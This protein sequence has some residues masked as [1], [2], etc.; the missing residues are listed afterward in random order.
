MT[1]QAVLEWVHVGSLAVVALAGAIYILGETV[2]RLNS[3]RPKR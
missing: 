2:I 1:P 3:M